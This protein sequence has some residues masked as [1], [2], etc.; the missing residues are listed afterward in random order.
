[1][2]DLFLQEKLIEA[3]WHKHLQYSDLL[4]V[5]LTA[6]ALLISGKLENKF[7]TESGHRNIFDR[8]VAKLGLSVIRKALKPAMQ[9]LAYPFVFAETIEQA[10]SS[11]SAE[12]LS[13]FL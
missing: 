5:N 10:V 2:Q 7:K 9:F 13:V 6:Q 8:V 1:M 11:K 4:R 12:R 3:G